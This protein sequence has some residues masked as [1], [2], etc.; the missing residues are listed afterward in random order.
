ML[1]KICHLNHF[2]YTFQ[3]HRGAHCGAAITTI[4]LQ[5]LQ[6]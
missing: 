2:K 1:N 6:N 5:N 3:W 4:Q